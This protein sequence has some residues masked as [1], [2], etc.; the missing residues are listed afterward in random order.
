[1][2]I[3]SYSDGARERLKGL[4]EDEGLSSALLIQNVSQ[5]GKQGL[6]LV[7]WNLEQG[8]STNTL[9]VISE[10]D[11]LGERLIRHASKRRK[12]ENFLTEAT[13]LSSGDLVVHVDHGI[14]KFHNLEVIK[15]VDALHECLVLEYAENSRLYLPV[16]NV[17]LLSK[18]G[19]EFGLLDKLGGAAWQAKKAKL[20]QRI[21]DMAERLIRVAAERELRTAPVFQPPPGIW[22]AFSAKF[23]YQETDDQMNA[24]EDVVSDLTS[25]RPM[26]RLV[27]GDVGFGK[28]E[29]AMRAAFLASISGFQV[30]VIAPTTLLVRQH[31]QSFLDRFRG[32][33]IEIRQLSRFVSKKTADKT[34][35]E[36]QN[37][38][39]DIVVG[40]HALLAKNIK[41]KNLGLLIIDE[42]QHF[43]VQHKERLKQLRSDIHVLTLSLIH[44]SE[45]TRPY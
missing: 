37:G 45:P 22:D 11:V 33:P 43:G 31:T 27:C 2:V 24:I 23:P 25:K 30:A 17:E 29:V 16:E 18:Y 4:L 7:V 3:A 44:I 36:I 39:V 20:K 38:N 10:Q 5:M 21:K 28:T 12:A 42:E 9:T 41:F 1:M 26:D 8:F 35:D 6:Y 34:R 14:G 32:L 13:S 15:A 19:Q 40:T